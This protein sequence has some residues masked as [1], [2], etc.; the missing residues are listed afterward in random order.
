[1]NRTSDFTL[2]DNYFSFS[3]SG[4]VNRTVRGIYA[5]LNSLSTLNTISPSIILCLF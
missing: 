2:E 1:M 5:L 4:S 3:L